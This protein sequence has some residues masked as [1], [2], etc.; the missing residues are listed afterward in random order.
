MEVIA[1]I[2]T[3][4]FDR[5]KHELIFYPE[6]DTEHDVDSNKLALEETFL[7]IHI[8]FYIFCLTLKRIA[9]CT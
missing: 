6:L 1:R 4:K 9:A 8:Y 3:S 7:F 5:T 2:G